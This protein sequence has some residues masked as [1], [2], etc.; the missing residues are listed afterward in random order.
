MKK[1]SIFINHLDDEIYNYF[2]EEILPTFSISAQNGLN[3]MFYKNLF[4]I[5]HII[6]QCNLDVSN[7]FKI[8]DFGC[9]LGINLMIL[10]GLFGFEC[11]GVD[12]GEEFSSEHNREVGNI[13]QLEN[14]LT[15]FGVKFIN[16][17]PTT[18]FES[19]LRVDVV[20]SFDVIEHFNFSPIVY[21]LNMQK[22]L[23]PGGSLLIGTPNQAHIYNRYKLLFGNNIW[24]DFE[25]WY[26]CKI[27]YGHVRELT[28]KE[29]IQIPK[30]MQFINT[31]IFS[32]SYPLIYRLKSKLIY[33]ILNFIFSFFNL[34]YYNLVIATKPF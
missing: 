17:D 1:K 31:R 34:N 3:N 26:N 13:N 30:K 5:K 19:H 27:F 18:E 29:L 25:Y 16:H 15:K 4:E 7:N 11:Y 21:L 10:S 24:E 14:R 23:K 22:S 12:R 20:T 6:N 9:G 33:R 28:T 32:S 8:M 2:K